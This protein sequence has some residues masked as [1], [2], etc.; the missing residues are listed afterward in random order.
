MTSLN[1]AVAFVTVMVPILGPQ[2]DLNVARALGLVA[3]L[4]RRMPKIGT[5]LEVPPALEHHADAAA[6]G[7]LQRARVQPLVVPDALHEP[8]TDGDGDV[9]AVGIA[10]DGGRVDFGKLRRMSSLRSSP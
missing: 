9:I 2:M 10:E 8:F 3:D 1:S 6:I 5:G 4:Q 7:R